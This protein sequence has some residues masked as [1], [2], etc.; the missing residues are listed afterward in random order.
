MRNHDLINYLSWW[1]QQFGEMAI[2]RDILRSGLD[3]HKE[4]IFQRMKN[5][6]EMDQKTAMQNYLG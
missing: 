3:Q 2:E 6:A 4:D 5:L 1:T